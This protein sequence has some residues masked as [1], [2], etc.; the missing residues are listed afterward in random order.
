MRI[1]RSLP[2]MII[3][4]IPTGL[5]GALVAIVVVEIGIGGTERDR[6]DVLE[7]VW[8]DSGSAAKT[9]S[10]ESEIL[11]FG[12][13]MIKHGLVP[14][15]FE[16]KQA[17][18]AYNLAMDGGP[19]AA[20]EILL[21]RALDSGAKPRAVIVDFELCFLNADIWAQ[22]GIWPEI[23]GFR[24]CWNLSWNARDPGFFAAMTLKLILPSLRDRIS[25]R[26]RILDSSAGRPVSHSRGLLSIKERHW[27][28]NRGADLLTAPPDFQGAFPTGEC[29]L[30]QSGGEMDRLNLGAIDRFVEIARRRK[31]LVFVLM[32]PILPE[33]QRLRESRGLHS[34]HVTFLRSLVERHPNLVVIDARNSGYG[35]NQFADY[36]HLN[37]EGAL[38]LSFDV[39][40]QVAQ[41]L[42]SETIPRWIRLSQFGIRAIAARTEDM[43]ESV[44]AIR[45]AHRTRQARNEVRLGSRP[46]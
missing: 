35:V 11:F 39:A 40:D 44:Q 25:L 28:V 26:Q 30:T 42:S 20:S 38:V 3:S 37:R 10:A 1:D 36:V 23:L 22:A 19:P 14:P 29:L 15:V 2:A 45:E 4:R 16:S 13:S 5:L 32:P 41:F 9:Q 31:I 17:L 18:R 21:K 8:N 7:M 33:V 46:R 24:D 6:A 43:S 27:R 12:D 34:R